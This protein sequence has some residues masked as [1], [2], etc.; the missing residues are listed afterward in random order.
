MNRQ[1]NDVNSLN[2]RSLEIL[3]RA[4]ELFRGNFSLIVVSCNYGSLRQKILTALAIKTGEQYRQIGW[5]EF[6]DI[7]TKSS[8]IWREDHDESQVE[9]ISALMCL[10]LEH[11]RPENQKGT[12][13]GRLH[14]GRA[15]LTKYFPRGI[16][17]P[18]AMCGFLAFG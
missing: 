2:G 15:S 9:H 14:C 12:S 6:Q 13:S 4:I 10:G 7:Y 3:A 1:L 16:H 11:T 18:C 5:N 17:P 8:K